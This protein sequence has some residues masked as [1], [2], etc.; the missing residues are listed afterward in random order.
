MGVKFWLRKIRI[1]GS[2]GR[3]NLKTMRFFKYMKTVS[4]VKLFLPTKKVIKKFK[5]NGRAIQKRHVRA[6]LD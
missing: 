5:V 4:F 2:T 3:E 1:S 6:V